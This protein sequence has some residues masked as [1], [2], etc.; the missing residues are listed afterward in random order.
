MQRL[1]IALISGLIFGAGLVISEM[2]NPVKVQD[3]LDPFGNWDPSLAFVMGGAVAVTLV[4]SRFIMK[5]KTPIIA[6]RFYMAVKNTIDARLI[7][8]A[9][10]FGIGWGL[11]GYCP[12]PGL[13]NA[14]INPTEA[15]LF[16]PALIVGGWIGQRYST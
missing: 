2:V 6:D 10:V 3:F 7:F 12:G 5:R 8:G 9:G 11:S 1:I 13:I 14:M 4:A 16:L 15:M